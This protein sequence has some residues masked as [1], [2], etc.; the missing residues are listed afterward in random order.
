MGESYDE[1]V[2]Q[3]ALDIQYGGSHYKDLAIQPFEYILKN[4]IGFA[5]GNAIK[6]LTRWKKKGGIQDL[7]KA[8]HFIDM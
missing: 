8:R 1:Q 6:Y 2:Y 7:E 3:S 5:E 4:N